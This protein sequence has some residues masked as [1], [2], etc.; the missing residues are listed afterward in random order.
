[1]VAELYMNVTLE[2]GPN[3]NLLVSIW[4]SFWIHT[5]Y[6][7]YLKLDPKSCSTFYVGIGS[8]FILAIWIRVQHDFELNPTH[9]YP[10]WNVKEIF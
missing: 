4:N 1:M 6:Y 5:L 3:L 2:L 8:K 9:L 10:S 7:I